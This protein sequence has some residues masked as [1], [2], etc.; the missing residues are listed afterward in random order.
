MKYLLLSPL[1][2]FNSEI[3]SLITLLLMMMFFFSDIAKERF[4]R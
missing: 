3:I 1:F 2:L 4:F